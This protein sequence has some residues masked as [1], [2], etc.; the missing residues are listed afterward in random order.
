[1]GFKHNQLCLV[2]CSVQ[3]APGTKGFRTNS[4]HK[5]ACRETAKH[6]R[7]RSKRAIFLAHLRELA[8]T[9][10]AV[11]TLERHHGS[12]APHIPT[13]GCPGNGGGYGAYGAGGKGLEQQAKTMMDML[14][15]MKGIQ[16]KGKGWGAKDKGKGKG[17]G[18]DG[19]RPA[20][21]QAKPPTAGQM[22]NGKGQAVDI[23]WTCTA[24]NAA[25]KICCQN[26]W[27]N[28]ARCVECGNIRDDQ[29]W[30]EVV[31]GKK[32]NAAPPAAP[33]IVPMAGKT[34]KA[35]VL[36]ALADIGVELPT[37]QP[38]VI[39]IV[40]E[41][42]DEKMQE[43]AGQDA[44]ALPP[45]TVNAKEVTGQR[46][47][48]EKQLQ[49]YRAF[50]GM[51]ELEAMLQ[52][53]LDALP[54]EITVVKESDVLKHIA[55]MQSCL[56]DL[57]KDE[58]KQ[59]LA[60]LKNIRNLEKQK[61]A[62]EAKMAA[63]KVKDA[64]RMEGSYAVMKSIN[65]KISELRTTHAV[66]VQELKPVVAVVQDAAAV[67]SQSAAVITEFIN[68]P[69]GNEFN[70]A[71]FHRCLAAMQAA[72]VVDPVAKVVAEH[73]FAQQQSVPMDHQ[74]EGEGSPVKPAEKR[75][76]NVSVEELNSMTGNSDLGGFMQ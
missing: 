21:P 7:E 4:E 52:A 67:R 48:L 28:K 71:E 57:S 50:G 54:V 60:D 37:V 31:S 63:Q 26:H 8:F 53:R 32:T 16:S 76:A 27:S 42:V 74:P 49:E 47:F 73:G 55:Y 45:P 3:C 66:G 69:G 19:K 64:K 5:S 25:G 68:S 2:N 14:V 24:V 12:T 59:Q 11:A 17:Q 33:V 15:A 70:N 58:E 13:M 35:Q 38:E 22:I 39:N 61:E 75:A 46:I 10:R 29:Q 44:H 62:I 65:N 36:K 30:S 40:I 43:E 51:P 41:E 34:G 23:A 72:P 56:A 18:Q 6:H 20:Q 9:A 1:M